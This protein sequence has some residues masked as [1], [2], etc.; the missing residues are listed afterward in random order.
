LIDINLA[1]THSGN[2]GVA[3]G[4]CQGG[5]LT[6]IKAAG[7]PGDETVLVALRRFPALAALLAVSMLICTVTGAG[8]EGL[9]AA[10]VVLRDQFEREVMPRLQIPDLELASY[11]RDLER[12][13]ALQGIVLAEPQLVVLVDRAPLVQALLILRGSPASGWALIGAAPVSTGVAGRFEHFLTP[14]GAFEHSMANPDFR[15]EGTKNELGIRGYGRKGSR[16]YDFG[17]RAQEKGWGKGGVSVM[18][19][20]MHSTD[21][22][23]LEQ[24]L[25]TAQSKGCI[26]IPD[27]LNQFIDRRGILD[28]AYQEALAGGARLWVLRT[29]REPTRWA[30]RWLVVVDSG[31]TERPPWSTAP[32]PRRR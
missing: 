4:G 13:L 1:A 16:V 15:A 27:S 26:R 5:V 11:V 21:P 28:A 2:S 20:Q 10:D 8:A 25:G 23:V 19:L 9:E 18:R 3:P 31:R 7:D 32:I 12:T 29:D 6:T 17:W 24:R 14:L 30:G 22:D